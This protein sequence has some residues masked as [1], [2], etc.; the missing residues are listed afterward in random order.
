MNS[1]LKIN[2][3]RAIRMGSA[4]ALDFLNRNGFVKGSVIRHSISRDGRFE[5]IVTDYHRFGN[6][7]DGSPYADRARLTEKCAI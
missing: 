5:T 3:D 6:R 2:T 7:E 1:L 4:E